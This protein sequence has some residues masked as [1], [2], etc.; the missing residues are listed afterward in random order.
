MKNQTL[1]V[2]TSEWTTHQPLIQSVMEV[3]KPR[4]ILELGMGNFSTPFFINKGAQY[5]GVE[6]DEKWIDHLK[7]NLGNMDT[8][9][10]DLGPNVKLGTHLYEINDEQKTSIINFYKSLKYPDLKPNVLFV[11]QFTCCRT[12]SINTLGNDFDVIMY[13]DCQPA[14]IPWYSYNLI[15]LD[16]FQIFTLKS[17]ISWTRLMV[18]HYDDSFTNV[19]QS[20][21][22]IYKKNNP[23][24]KYMEFTK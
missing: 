5:L 4:F 2:S 17:D 14:G 22:Q 10:H 6:N 1:G 13:H 16:G 3:Y 20:F 8:I 24:I 15:N 9:F 18:K 19:V 7:N 12:L 23:D 21:I 11:D